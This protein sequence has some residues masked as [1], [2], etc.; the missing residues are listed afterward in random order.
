MRA[1]TLMAGLVKP[2]IGTAVA[3]VFIAACDFPHPGNPHPPTDAGVGGAQS[4]PDAAADAA[5]DAEPLP[6][7]LPPCLREALSPCLPA[8]DSCFSER[9]PP[10][11]EFPDPYSDKICAAGSS[12]SHE[13][14]YAYHSVIKTI[15]QNGTACFGE[16]MQWGIGFGPITRYFDSSGA[17][18]AFG[19]S[20][21]DGSGD[22][23]VFCTS[24]T[25]SQGDVSYPLTRA[26]PLP[27]HRCQATTPG[28]CP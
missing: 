6:E 16:N 1:S 25:P 3:G 19:V 11:A 14:A 5:P 23:Q 2:L 15:T 26:C 18:V 28:N 17:Q 24:G 9:E 8:L 20:S 13:T 12:W 22:V 21:T 4:Q 10:G 7:C 27:T